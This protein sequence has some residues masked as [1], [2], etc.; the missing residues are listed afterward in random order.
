MEVANQEN[1]LIQAKNMGIKIKRINE[2]KPE[3]LKFLKRPLIDAAPM[4]TLL[5]RLHI[6]QFV[7]KRLSNE[8]YIKE[9]S[10]YVFDST[11]VCLGLLEVMRTTRTK[12]VRCDFVFDFGGSS[13]AFVENISTNIF[14]ALFTPLLLKIYK[15]ELEEIQILVEHGR[16]VNL[17]SIFRK[18]SVSHFKLELLTNRKLSN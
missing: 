16:H 9:A 4:L 10:Y 12:I 11:S 8:A 1:P 15:H 13:S 6:E 7:E 5:P 18:I 14:K 17:L 3:D 2:L